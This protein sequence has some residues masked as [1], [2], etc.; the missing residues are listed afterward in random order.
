MKEYESILNDKKGKI[1]KLAPKLWEK[2]DE[3]NINKRKKL[4]DEIK[5]ISL[6]LKLIT[7][8]PLKTEKIIKI[9]KQ[10]ETSEDYRMHM[11]WLDKDY[12]EPD[13][14]DKD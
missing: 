10:F 9:K 12:I 2:S 5:K 6:S 14:F 1:R 7:N 13:E 11:M 8:N 3:V 4:R